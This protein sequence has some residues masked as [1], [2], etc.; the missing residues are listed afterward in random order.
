[1]AA[2]SQA[3][4]TADEPESD[5]IETLIQLSEQESF[6]IPDEG[7]HF[8]PLEEAPTV[9]VVEHPEYALYINAVRNVH[10]RHGEIAV[11][12]P[13]KIVAH[14]DEDVADLKIFIHQ[15]LAVTAPHSNH[16]SP[17]EIPGF[18]FARV[19]ASVVGREDG[20]GSESVKMRYIVV[21]DRT[22]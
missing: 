22:A 1:M 12:T 5:T 6:T 21:Y 14:T 19:D 2:Q 18:E 11:G 10:D 13:T 20:D 16:I 3:T 9:D 4:Q 15:S 7:D 8:G 17:I